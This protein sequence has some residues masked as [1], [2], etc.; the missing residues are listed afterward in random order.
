[1]GG[2]DHL[3][4]RNP[5]RSA[6]SLTEVPCERARGGGARGRRAPPRHPCPPNRDRW[7]K[8]ISVYF[9]SGDLQLRAYLFP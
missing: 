3:L 1:M 9:Q 7:L 5:L 4:P 6:W 8:L 2:D